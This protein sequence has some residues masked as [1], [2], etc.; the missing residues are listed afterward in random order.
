M[1]KRKL[2]DGRI[3]ALYERLSRDDDLAG[4]SYSIVNQKKMLEEYAAQLGFTNIRHFTDDGYTGANFDRPAWQEM[5]AGVEDGSIGAIIAKDM[6]R[7]GRNYLQVGFYTEVLFP[8]KKVRFIAISNGVDSIDSTGSEFVPFLNIMNEWYLRDCS[9]KVKAAYHAK[10]KSGRPITSN[11]P[12]GYIKDPD[13]KDK[14]LVDVEAAAVVKRIFQLTVDGNGPFRIARILHDEK[15]IRPSNHDAAQDKGTYRYKSDPDRQY[16]WTGGTVS[17]IIE[18]QEYMGDTVNFRWYKDSYKDKRQK[19]AEPGGWVIFKNT[20]EPIIDRKT[21]YLAQELRKTVRRTET[22]TKEP[23]PLTGKLYCAECGAKMTHHHGGNRM[24]RNWR[25]APTGVLTKTNPS[26]NCSTYTKARKNHWELTCK[27]HFILASAANELILETIRY[28]CANV[29][30]DEEAFIEAV[31]SAATVRDKEAAKKVTRTLQKNQKRFAEIDRLIKKVYEDNANGKISDRRYEMLS[32]DY[33]KEQ[34][35]LE[36][37]IAMAK[38]ELL[39]YEED[40]DR[41]NDFI[42]LAKKY[43]EFTEL[44]PAMI[45]E[46]IDKVIVHKAERIDGERVME[47]EVYLN[48][49]GKVVLPAQEMTPEEIEAH[50]KKVARKE[51]LRNYQREYRKKIRAEEKVKTE[52]ERAKATKKRI[53]EAKIQAAKAMEEAEKTAA[54]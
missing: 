21:W 12:Y 14:W 34:E 8:E 23:L 45:N 28:A 22:V 5:L 41:T 48:F 43:T 10:G 24:A 44:T 53:R 38:A 49:I 35:E 3:T 16:N 25:G 17:R 52:K 15:V 47:I 39:Q 11:P 42:A 31:R 33:E 40:S 46:F 51:Y 29:R 9:R 18:R 26:Y 4:D 2:T 27:S 36:E 32:T 13:D 6:S 37:A 20:H 30:E 1:S 54:V 7:I 50:K 19:L